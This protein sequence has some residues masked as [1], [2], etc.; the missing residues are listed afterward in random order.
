M[1][2]TDKFDAG[3][4]AG[5]RKFSVFRQEPIAR[6]DGVYALGFCEGDD[7]GDVQVCIDWGFALTDAIGFICDGTIQRVLIFFR[8]DGDALDPE[9]LAGAENT[10][11][12]LATVCY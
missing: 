3:F 1:V 12:D 8:I 2:R 4:F 6:M 7:A 5:L 9:L 10:D 11:S